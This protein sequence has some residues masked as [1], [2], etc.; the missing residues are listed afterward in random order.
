MEQ[1]HPESLKQGRSVVFTK[2]FQNLEFHQTTGQSQPG[3]SCQL[4]ETFVPS[5]ELE[6]AVCGRMTP[7][8]MNI[9]QQMWHIFRKPT[10]RGIELVAPSI[11]AAS[12]HSVG[13]VH[14]CD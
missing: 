7:P 4:L 11:L 13:L 9:R 10:G 6:M 5:H 14:C 8:G 2:E 3:G 12:I 1:K